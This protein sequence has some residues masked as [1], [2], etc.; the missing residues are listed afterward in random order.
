MLFRY[1]IHSIFSLSIDIWQ[2]KNGDVPDLATSLY[3]MDHYIINPFIQL[4]CLQGSNT[5]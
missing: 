4:C 1:K 2:I 3:H 5:L